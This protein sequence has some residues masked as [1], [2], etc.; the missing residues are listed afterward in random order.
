MEKYIGTIIVAAVLVLVV[1]F[2]IYRMIK[3]RK[4]GKGC[5]GNCASCGGHCSHTS[6]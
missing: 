6:R 5:T 1:G 4:S 3:D 2:V